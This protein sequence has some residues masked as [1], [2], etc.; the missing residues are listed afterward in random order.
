MQG[1]QRVHSDHSLRRTEKGMQGMKQE[2]NMMGYL[3][4][5]FLTQPS[6]RRTF[7]LSRVALKS[8]IVAKAA[9]Q[10]DRETTLTT[11]D[12]KLKTTVKVVGKIR[13]LPATAAN[14]D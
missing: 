1:E 4:Q 10:V 9:A 5:K 7:T 8:P 3:K 2:Q 14:G 13:K 6:K 12:L 11:C